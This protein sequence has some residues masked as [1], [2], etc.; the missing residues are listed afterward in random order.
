MKVEHLAPD[1]LFD[2]Q[3]FE[4]TQVVTVEG[5]RKTIY[6][7]GQT[8]MGKD[9]AV[10]GVGDMARQA[11]EAYR[12]VLL[13]LAAAGATPAQ[14]VF[15]RNYVVG[16]N[17]SHIEVLNQARRKAWGPHQPPAATLLG[18]AALALPDILIEVE[19]VA[20]AD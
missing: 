1:T 14:V 9:L 2:S 12:N 5:G 8:A 7:A 18:V 3:P 11:E 15:L 16:Y 10:V 20:V 17:P 6:C 13:A 19:A 4:F